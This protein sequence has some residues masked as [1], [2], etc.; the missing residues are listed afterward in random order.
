V[1]QRP[2]RPRD[3]P[4]HLSTRRDLLRCACRAGDAQRPERRLLPSRR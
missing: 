2:N 1:R 4:R 3:F